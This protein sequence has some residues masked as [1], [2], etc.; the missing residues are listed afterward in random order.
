M[1]INN[2][3]KEVELVLRHIRVLKVLREKGPLG[4]R[5]ISAETGIPKHQVRYSLRVLERAGALNPTSRGA[6]L[7]DGVDSYVEDLV[8]NLERLETQLTELVELARELRVT[9]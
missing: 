9:D 5:R 2:L 1:S 6:R 7:T 8:V 3:R 4:I